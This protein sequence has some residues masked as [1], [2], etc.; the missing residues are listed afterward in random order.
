MAHKD[1]DH[2]APQPYLLKQRF[3]VFVT[4]CQTDP[5]IP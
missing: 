4:K 5:V 3:K 1:N 2:N